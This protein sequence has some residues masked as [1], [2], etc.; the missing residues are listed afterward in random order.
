[1]RLYNGSYYA[2]ACSTLKRRQQLDTTVSPANL[3]KMSPATVLV[4]N[5]SKSHHLSR[6]EKY[7]AA[8]PQS[9]KLNDFL[10]LLSCKLTFPQSGPPVPM[11]LCTALLQ[12]QGCCNLQSRKPTATILQTHL[13]AKRAISADAAVIS[14]ALLHTQNPANI[15]KPPAS[16]C[17]LTFLQSVPL[18]PKLL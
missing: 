11:L 6:P 13:P 7:V 9:C 10:L 2:C 15:P 3:L 14:I 5:S 18:A 1:M 12:H 8:E 16:I 4:T 17:K